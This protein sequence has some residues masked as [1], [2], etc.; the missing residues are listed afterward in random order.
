MSSKS[1]H[2]GHMLQSSGWF[3]YHSTLSLSEICNQKQILGNG[4]CGYRTLLK[5]LKNKKL[6]EDKDKNGHTINMLHLRKKVCEVAERVQAGTAG[7][8]EAILQINN[9]CPEVIAE[10]D[11]ERIKFL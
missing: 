9:N 4:N 10:G 2:N 6:F 3:W 5:G 7:M 1:H 11:E 8:V